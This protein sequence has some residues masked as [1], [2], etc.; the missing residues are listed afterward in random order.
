VKNGPC[1]ASNR[2]ISSCVR[3]L[4]TLQSQQNRAKESQEEKNDRGPKKRSKSVIDA[5]RTVHKDAVIE[6]RELESAVVRNL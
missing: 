6:Y 4:R 5:G 1:E 2:S 3:K